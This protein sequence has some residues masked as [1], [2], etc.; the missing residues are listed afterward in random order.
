MRN[1]LRN[2]AVV[3]VLLVTLGVLLAS[4]QTA[5]MHAGGISSRGVPASVTSFGFGGHPGFH[6]VPASVTSQ[7]FGAGH[8]FR[9]FPGHVT[10]FGF[11]GHNGFHA[12]PF[13]SGRRRLHRPFARYS[14]Y[15]GGYYNY[16]PYAYPYYLN[17]DD[18]SD[19]AS[20]E[21]YPDD[22]Y[23]S[24]DARQILENDYR[25]GVDV[26]VEQVP[27][28]RPEPVVAQPSTVL[29]FKDGRQQ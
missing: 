19:S 8:N 2:A 25:A 20:Y 1:A 16:A 17:D 14:P 5:G 24:D 4:A 10:T 12:H 21:S 15:Y 18:D 7:G 23:R 27:Q 22:D 29:I 26:P 11:E 9:G 13:E 6:G 3:P 28:R